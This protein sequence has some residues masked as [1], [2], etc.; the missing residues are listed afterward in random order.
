MRAG[1]VAALDA[2]KERL[3]SFRQELQNLRKSKSSEK[4]GKDSKESLERVSS[5]MV[6][7]KAATSS[8]AEMLGSMMPLAMMSGMLASMRGLGG[9]SSEKKKGPMSS[10]ESPFAFLA[11]LDE[12]TSSKSKEVEPEPKFKTFSAEIKSPFAMGPLGMMSSLLSSGS[13]LSSVTKGLGDDSSEEKETKSGSPLEHLKLD[14]GSLEDL[15]DEVQKSVSDG[16]V[17]MMI[18]NAGKEDGDPLTS[19]VGTFTE[20]VSLFFFFLCQRGNL[21]IGSLFGKLASTLGTVSFHHI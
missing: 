2:A 9:S 21:Q 14:E 10:M 16:A 5:S 1:K 4:K 17:K 15:K 7:K 19:S 11:S 3:E 20:I 6:S 18:S 12:P 8:S 13:L